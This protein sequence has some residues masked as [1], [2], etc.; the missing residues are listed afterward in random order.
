[1]DELSQ[2]LEEA[3]AVRQETEAKLAHAEKKIIELEQLSG[4]VKVGRYCSHHQFL[5][6][7]FLGS[8]LLDFSTYPS[9]EL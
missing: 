6:N 3:I 7:I 8:E 1:L 4:S 2:K 9:S 5:L